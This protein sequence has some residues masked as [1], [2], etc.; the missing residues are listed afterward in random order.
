MATK[1]AATPATAPTASN[2]GLTVTAHVGD[3]AVLLAFD[4]DPAKTKN[5]AG[6]AVQVTPQNGKPYFLVNRLSFQNKL[7]SANGLND[8]PASAPS[9]AKYVST[10]GAPIQMFHW[11]HFPPEGT[12]T[13]TYV[14]TA[15]YFTGTG[16]TLKDGGKVSLDVVIDDQQLT[17]LS[18]GMTRGYVSSQAFIDKFASFDSNGA[19]QLWPKPQT[20]DFP[21][22]KYEQVYQY[23]G[24]H[25][26]K[27]V[28]DFL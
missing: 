24:A 12:G 6:F 15:R 22:A 25:G 1:P 9:A 16:T 7:T 11:V 21:T 4:I 23:L 5:F 26:R 17:N 18:V 19:A 28:F 20:I 8:G 3:R 14:V 27:L 2:G 10:N 13:F